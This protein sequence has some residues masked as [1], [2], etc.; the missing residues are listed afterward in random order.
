MSFE[1][2]LHVVD[3]DVDVHFEFA[4]D[5]DVVTTHGVTWVPGMV[6]QRDLN[7]ADDDREVT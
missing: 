3:H 1:V 6:M 2:V 4:S 7:D 5:V